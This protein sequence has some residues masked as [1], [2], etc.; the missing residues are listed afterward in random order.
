MGTLAVESWFALGIVGLIAAVFSAYAV[1]TAVAG[2]KP[3][4]RVV[5]E[6][7]S[8]LLGTFTMEA[9]YWSFRKVGEAIAKTGLTPDMLTWT[10]LF[11]TLGSI[12]F[13]AK[14]ELGLAGVLLMAGSVFD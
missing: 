10:S 6:G 3:D 13:A 2:R 14:G 7:R 5:K 9:F 1:R 11:V 4:P 12:P 8:V